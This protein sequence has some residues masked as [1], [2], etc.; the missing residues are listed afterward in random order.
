MKYAIIASVCLFL[1]TALATPIG[2]SEHPNVQ[3]RQ[4]EDTYQEKLYLSNGCSR[5]KKDLINQA[6]S[7]AGM[8]ARAHF[9]WEP[10]RAYQPAMD[11]YMGTKS[12][13]DPWFFGESYRKI[14]L[15]NI[16]RQYDLHMGNYPYLTYTYIYC[17]DRKVWPG[18]CKKGG[19]A[20]E[21][22]EIGHWYG[23]TN[24]LIVLCDPFFNK[25]V[26]LKTV[27]DKGDGGNN[28]M[29]EKLDV[30]KTTQ[31]WTMFHET[32]H[33][34]DTVSRPH[35]IDVLKVVQKR[36]NLNNPPRPSACMHG[37]RCVNS[38]N[39]DL[40]GE[41]EEAVLTGTDISWASPTFDTSQT[42]EPP[43]SEWEHAN[44][45]NLDPK[46]YLGS[47]YKD[48]PKIDLTPN[49]CF[50][51]DPNATFAREVDLRGNIGTFCGEFNGQVVDKEHKFEESYGISINKTGLS[52]LFT[53]TSVD[54]FLTLSI[55]WHDHFDCN[56]RPFQLYQDDCETAMVKS[57]L[58][59]CDEGKTDKAGGY[60]ILYKYLSS[61]F[62]LPAPSTHLAN[63][64]P[65]PATAANIP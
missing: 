2:F 33:M 6:W 54:G 11:M 30:Y 19:Y 26:P 16:K 64:P 48:D 65:L 58:E 37:N 40:L 15:G 46:F 5:N 36:W 39:K 59:K 10:T 7:E 62:F 61:V 21:K 24:H 18:L 23:W 32:Y 35:A 13:Q 44:P 38:N 34:E 60:K 1:T 25:K 27:L 50:S 3:R 41:E 14:I 31:A 12:V 43:E 63:L 22:D 4:G 45:P 47:D 52:S 29:K 57:V 42:T 56:D 55:K 28:T 49:K 51:N 17:D 8:L 20:Y 9:L 53:R